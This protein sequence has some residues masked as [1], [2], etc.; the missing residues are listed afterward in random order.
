MFGL[1]GEADMKMLQA[2]EEP[3][4]AAGYTAAELNV[5]TFRMTAKPPNW[6]TEHLGAIQESIRQAKS[7]AR[8][9]EKRE[10]EA[11][12]TAEHSVCSDCRNSGWAVVPH[13]KG[14]VNGEWQEDGTGQRNTMAVSCHCGI[15]QRIW[16][17]RTRYAADA[18]G[19]M[20]RAKTWV[21]MTFAAY[22]E[23]NPNWRAQLRQEQERKAAMQAAH[24]QAAHGDRVYGEILRATLAKQKESEYA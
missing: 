11:A 5:A 18:K 4:E 21:P 15:G 13:S 16:N 12:R 14:I 1:N 3:F 24:G 6:R 19:Q 20:E 8:Q 7:A 23:K 22:A 10:A 2:W 9:Q 17:D